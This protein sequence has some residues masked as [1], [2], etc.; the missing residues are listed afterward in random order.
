MNQI[1]AYI[2][3][4]A[5]ARQMD[6]N[7]A[8]R[9]AQSE[10]GLNDPIRQSDYVKNGKRERSYGP[11]QL[12]ID[13]GLGNRA[14]EAGID[15]RD[16]NQWQ[17][18]VDF[19][20]DEA[21]QKGWGQWYGAAKAGIGNYDGIKGARPVGVTPALSP[22]AADFVLNNPQPGGFGPGV[23]DPNSPPIFGSMSA[24]LGQTGPDN[25]IDPNVAAFAFGEDNKGRGAAVANA[26]AGAFEPVKAPSIAKMPSPSG[27]VANGLMKLMQNPQALAQLLMKQRMG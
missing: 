22:E 10:G 26:I 3:Q 25:S 20:L 2:R 15:P 18:G 23:P 17:R 13:G 21:S 5:R 19:A 1:E 16:P 14:L 27:D 8:V 4:A 6:E 9:V 7:I 11:F 12:Y 24:G